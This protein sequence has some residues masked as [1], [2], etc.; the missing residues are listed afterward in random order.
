MKLTVLGLDPAMRNF[1][2]A[3]AEIAPKGA[4]RVIDCGV[5]RTKPEHKKRN[6]LVANDNMRCVQM[7]TKK[8]LAIVDSNKRS[9]P[10]VAI[11]AESPAGS[12]SARSANQLGLAWGIVGTL[13]ACV[14]LPVFNETAMGVKAAMTGDKTASKARIQEAVRDQVEF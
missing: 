2:W 14:G 8:L 9:D 1:G 7:I 4:V 10:I 13:A 5:V 11:C 3:L 6:T 12:Q